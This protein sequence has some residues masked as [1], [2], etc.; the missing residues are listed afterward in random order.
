[1]GDSF[2]SGRAPDINLD[3]LEKPEEDRRQLIAIT[4]TPKIPEFSFNPEIYDPEDTKIGLDLSKY[5]E[6]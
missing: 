4:L 2:M 5:I 1:M 3:E 6:T